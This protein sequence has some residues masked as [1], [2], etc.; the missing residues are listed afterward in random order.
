M[1]GTQKIDYINDLFD[2]ILNAQKHANESLS[3]LY[4]MRVTMLLTKKSN[5]DHLYR[6]SAKFKI[7]LQRIAEHFK[8][9]I[10]ETQDELL[11]EIVLYEIDFFRM[12][13]GH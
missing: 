9:H 1:Q 4:F 10:K 2:F 6:Q 5:N 13:M 8:Q 12:L 11:M 3:F 7:V